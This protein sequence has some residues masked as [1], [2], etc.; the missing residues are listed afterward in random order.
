[1]SSLYEIKHFFMALSEYID[2]FLANKYAQTF[3][4]KNSNTINQPQDRSTL[5]KV[6]AV[7]LK[8]IQE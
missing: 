5:K 4:Y 6:D 7:Q 1:M 3:L 2:Y 8:T